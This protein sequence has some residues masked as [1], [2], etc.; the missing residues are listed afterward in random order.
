M[1]RFPFVGAWGNNVLDSVDG[2]VLRE[3]GVPEET[4]QT[5]D[6]AADSF[7]YVVMLIVGRR[8]RIR[9][10]IV[11]LFLYRTIGQALFFKTRKEIV[12]LCFPN[13]LEPLVLAYTLLLY[14]HKGRE[15]RAY[16]AYRQHRGHIWIAIIAYKLWN[17]WSLHAA[18]IDLSERIFGFTGGARERTPLPGP[19]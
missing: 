1:P 17:E 6:K 4:Y 12:F 18:N 15:P 14:R 3:L 10:L 11:L 9:R 13:F 16:A 8:W 19:P 2:D 7:S 5:I